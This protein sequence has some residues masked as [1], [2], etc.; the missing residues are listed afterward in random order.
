[1]LALPTVFGQHGD[2]DSGEGSAGGSLVAVLNAETYSEFRRW[3][4]ESGCRCCALAAGRQHIVVDRG[5]P[6]AQGIAF[7]GRAGR[8]L[9]E[10]FA[11]GGLS[12]DKAPSPRER[13]E[14]PS[15]R[16]PSAPAGGNGQLPT[17]PR[18]A[19]RV[20]SGEIHCADGV[21]GAKGLRPRAE[22]IERPCGPVLPATTMATT[23]VPHAAPPGARSRQPVAGAA[24]AEARRGAGGARRS[25]IRN[26]RRAG[27]RHQRHVTYSVHLTWAGTTT[28]R[29][30]ARSAPGRGFEGCAPVRPLLRQ[31]RERPGVRRGA[32]HPLARAQ[33]GHTRYAGLASKWPAGS[34][35]LPGQCGPGDHRQQGTRRRRR[36]GNG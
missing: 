15:A 9:D 26:A 10:L 1:M 13:S 32:Q 16:Q 8:K 36:P 25:V 21:H 24:R 34:G 3:L 27:A 5:N 23:G 14:M 7:R 2:A 29:R 17:I 18:A 4:H 19:V 20:L 35:A 11:A 6:D 22:G 28:A 33:C 12:T 30:C 31:R